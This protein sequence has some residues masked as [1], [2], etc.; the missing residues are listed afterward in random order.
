MRSPTPAARRCIPRILGLPSSGEA[1]RLRVVDLVHARTE[2]GEEPDLESSSAA[3]M[4]TAQHTRSGTDS[5]VPAKVHRVRSGCMVT[6]L[7]C[8]KACGGRSPRAFR[9]G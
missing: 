9:R 8:T 7:P 3:A 6:I 1:G 4:L 2:T 5:F